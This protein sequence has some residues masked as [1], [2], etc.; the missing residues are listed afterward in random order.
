MLERLLRN[1]WHNILGGAWSYVLVAGIFTLLWLWWHFLPGRRQRLQAKRVGRPQLQ[2]EVLTTVVSLTVIGAVLPL[3]FALGLRRYSP[4]YTGLD[5]YSHG[6]ASTA[7]IVVL[8]MIVQ[9]TWFYWTHRLM[10][11]RRLFRW[12]HLTHHRSTNT[13]PWSTYSISPVEAV[14]DSSAIIVILLL[15][16]RNYVALFIFSWLN[17]AYAVYTHLGYEIF[18]RGMS[19]HWLGRWVNTSTAHNTHHAR[20]RYNYGWYFLF[21]DRMMGTLSPD[22]ET[23]YSKAGFLAASAKSR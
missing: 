10:H 13:N 12:T 7:G 15:V 21:W 2:R 19:Q 1:I 6:W 8:M 14:V 20:G 3:A 4:I 11:H 16:P 22:Y 18:P 23:H 5:D 17:T 9:D